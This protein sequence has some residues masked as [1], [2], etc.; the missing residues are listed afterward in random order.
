MGEHEYVAGYV[1]CV[2]KEDPAS[3]EEVATDGMKLA[4]VLYTSF[5]PKFCR[6]Q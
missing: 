4:M 5:A 1:S 3:F 6:A 2:L